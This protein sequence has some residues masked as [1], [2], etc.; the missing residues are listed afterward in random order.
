MSPDPAKPTPHGVELAIN[1]IWEVHP[2]QVK[3]C[4]DK[5][6]DVLLLDVRRPDEFAKARINGATL[7]PMNELEARLQP[8]LSQHKS[9]PIVVYCHHGARSLRATAF[10]RHHGFENVHSLAGG[11]DAYSL[12]ADTSIPRY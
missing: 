4:L 6:E 2:A 8:E 1:P 3:E 10:L 12:I 5:K 9:R 7:I 11:I